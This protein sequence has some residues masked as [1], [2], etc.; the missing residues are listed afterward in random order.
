MEM[1]DETKKPSFWLNMDH[2]TNMVKLHRYNCIHCSP[3]PSK[4][5][6]VNSLHRN[7]DWIGFSSA[8]DARE[9]HE[10]K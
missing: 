8:Q 2:S 10:E 9:Y 7:G 6:E 5:K 4:T 1:D 3:E